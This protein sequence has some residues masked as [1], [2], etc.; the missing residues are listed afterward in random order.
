MRM[1]DPSGD[2]VQRAPVQIQR[3]CPECEDELQ[4]S[5]VG[6]RRQP[7]DFVF[8]GV[9]EDERLQAK[10]VAGQTPQVTPEMESQLADLQ[11][12]GQQCPASVRAY[13]EPRLGYDLSPVRIHTDA[14]AY[15]MARAVR[16]RAFTLGPHIVFGEGEHAPAT[17]EGRR[18]LA[19][20][21]THTIQ[22]GGVRQ[23]ASART[24]TSSP[25]PIASS[26]ALRP[27][28]A[29]TFH[30][31]ADDPEGRLQLLRLRQHGIIEARYVLEA[32]GD[33]PR[34]EG[35]WRLLRPIR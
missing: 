9:E 26:E 1:P 11:G 31:A 4:R 22:Q 34:D 2:V 29:G 19:H 32:R 35:T 23:K 10:A 24:G 12:R 8:E 18:L 16:A 5:P 7:T 17:S 3:M 14:R 21:L 25:A 6:I 27:C 20:E 33:R 13:F 28:R 30:S 15:E